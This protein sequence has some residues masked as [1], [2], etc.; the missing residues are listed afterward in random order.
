MEL[1]EGYKKTEVGIIPEDWDV[2]QISEAFD[3]CNNLRL[4]I[5]EDNRKKMQGIY[6]YYGP[7]KIQ[8]YI[9]EYRVEGEYALIGED[10]D[11]FL[12]WQDS[13]MTQLANGKFNVN[14]H[15]H[16]LKGKDGITT[17]KWFYYFF[18]HRDITPFLTRQGAGRY[19]LSKSSLA[20]VPCII[21]TSTSEQ[22]K[23]ARVLSDTD[24][25]IQALEKK[26]AKKKLIKKG[27]MQKLL[28]PMEGWDNVRLSS[29]GKCYRGVSYNGENDLKSCDAINTFRLLRSNNVLENKLIFKEYQIVIGERVSENQIMKNGDILIC[30]ANGSKKLVGKS[31][32]YLAIDSFKYTFGAFMGV[33][34]IY[35][36]M[37]NP[38]FLFI[39]FQ[40]FQYRKYIELLLSGSSI[41]N[42]RPSDIESIEIKVPLIEEQNKIAQILSDIDKEIE[43]L[44]QKLN[45]YKQVKQGMMQQLLTG[46]I[47]LEKFKNNAQ[48]DN[49]AM[50]AEPNES[51]QQKN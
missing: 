24:A 7:T 44:E 50:A 40:T 2:M 3:I 20:K 47:R 1:K 5:S 17:T 15:A 22:D 31:S 37:C 49:L 12:K 16:L 13:P 46:K 32:Q 41:N 48:E 10:G 39:N 43:Q 18:N 42:L 21:P 38:F 28:T 34:R 35:P 4:P 25:L 9:N 36:E 51:Y 27:V 30:M 29:L 6:P 14:N 19:K 33:F 11:H 8:D 23:I 26:I 45:K